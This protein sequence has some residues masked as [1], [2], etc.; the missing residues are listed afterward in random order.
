MEVNWDEIE[1]Q[2]TEIPQPATA[3]SVSHKP[4]VVSNEMDDTTTFVV[5]Q[6]SGSVGGHKQYAP[7]VAQIP[8]EGGRTPYL[9]MKPDGGQ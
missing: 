4:N 5:S 8:D 2:Y 9:I 3:E 6:S 1:R 7:N